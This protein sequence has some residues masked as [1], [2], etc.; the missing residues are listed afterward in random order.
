M[1]I[2]TEE[3]MDA[4]F[5]GA[6][7]TLATNLPTVNVVAQR[8]SYQ[9]GSSYF[10]SLSNG[11]SGYHSE[12]TCG[13]PS[14]PKVEYPIHTNNYVSPSKLRCLIDQAADPGHGSVASYDMKY[15]SSWAWLKSTD[16]S[17]SHMQLSNYRGIPVYPNP[18]TDTY[19]AT[20][21]QVLV[22][23]TSY[24]TSEGLTT[25]TAGTVTLYGGAFEA[26]PAGT[27]SKPHYN[28]LGD[29][30]ASRSL[31]AMSSQ[32]KLIMVGAHEFQ[33][34]YQLMNPSYLG[35]RNNELDAETFAL[36]ALDRYRAN[37][38]TIDAACK[39]K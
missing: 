3:E 4:V 35:A 29:Y 32:E 18:G 21:G 19:V 9:S 1:R 22:E 23:P 17:H 30:V 14:G 2:L 13:C 11:Y 7:G 25:W 8:S 5:G 38:A 24:V 34:V 33:H 6:D 16:V 10:Y 37:K 20:N 31:G 26:Q 28:E 15:V 27:K 39:N 36:K 12:Q